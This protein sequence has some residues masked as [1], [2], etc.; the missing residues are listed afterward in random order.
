MKEFE[1]E[2]YLRKNGIS[3]SELTESLADAIKHFE[4]VFG[5]Y[6]PN[7]IGEDGKE[8]L[9]LSKSLKEDIKEELSD[10]ELAEDL[11]E[12]EA[13][14]WALEKIL[15][16]KYE[17]KVLFSKLKE[18]GYSK[19]IPSLNKPQIIGNQY[20]IVKVF[21]SKRVLIQKRRK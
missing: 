21:G 19:P 7:T 4:D 11:T 15:N 2:K 18:L 20:R 1:H 5:D 9:A 10:A 14:I 6:D 3:I 12:A 8:I 13:N 17:Q 16:G